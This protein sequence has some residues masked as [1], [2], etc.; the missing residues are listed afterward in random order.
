MGKIT[1]D[2]STSS[3]TSDDSNKGGL[4]DVHLVDT[5]GTFDST[6]SEDNT[7]RSAAYLRVI[8]GSSLSDPSEPVKDL[9]YEGSAEEN[10]CEEKTYQQTGFEKWLNILLCRGDLAKEALEA[11]PVSFTGLFLFASSKDRLM[12]YTGI[13]LSII[14]GVAQPMSMWL[15]GRL[16]NVLIVN[17]DG[18]HSDSLWD[19]GYLIVKVNAGIGLSLIVVTFLQY[20]FLRVACTNITT[21]LRTRFLQSM[22]RQDAGWCDTQKF[23]A[24]NA[25]LNEN[26]DRIRDGIGDKI[27][28]LIRG[29]SMFLSTQILSFI[30]DWQIALIMLPVGPLSCLTMS[31]MARLVSR[32][33]QKHLDSV[34][35][36]GAVLQETIMN[37]KTVQSCNGED[38]MVGKYQHELDKGRFH[39]IM[40][41]FWN[42]LFDGFF[43]LILYGFYVVGFYYGSM[44]FTDGTASAGDVF[45]VT[46]LVL[47]GAYFLGVMSPHIMCILKAR[48]AAAV[49][50]DRIDRTPTIDC[51]SDEGKVIR[52][53]KG[54][55]E[56]KDV[57]FSYPSRKARKVLKGV[58]WRADAGETVALV[59][60]SGCGKSTSIGLITRLYECSVGA[61]SIDGIDVKQL[62]IHALRRMIGIVQQEPT[63]FNGSIY[64]NI[65]LGDDTV[66]YKRVEEVCRMANAHGFIEKLQDGY[67]TVIGSGSVQLSGGQKQ[68]IAIARAIVHNPPI[69]LLDEATSALDAESEILVQT[70][71]KDASKGRTTV[72]IAHRLSTLRDVNKIVVMDAGRVVETGSHESLCQMPDGVYSKL[73]KAQQFME[74][75]AK[76]HETVDGHHDFKRNGT[77][78]SSMESTLSRSSVRDITT[79]PSFRAS[80]KEADESST[81]AASTSSKAWSAFLGKGLLQLYENCSGHYGKMVAGTIFSFLRGLELMLYVLLMSLGFQAFQ[82]FLDTTKGGYATFRVEIIWFTAFGASLGVYCMGSI[83]LGVAVYG[84]AAEN[85]VDAL[86]VRALKNIL[87]QDGAY[88]DRPETGNAKLIQRITSDAPTLKAAL[89]TRLYHVVNNLTALGSLVI[90]SLIY[91]WQIALIGIAVFTVLVGILSI[92]GSR[93]QKTL[94]DVGTLDDSPKQAVEIIENVRTIQL[95]TREGYFLG[96]YTRKLAEIRSLL[97]RASVYDSVSFAL[98]QSF[99][100]ISDMAC[101]GLGIYLIYHGITSP[102]SVFV[103]AMNC[104]TA[105]WAILFVSVSFNEI[106]R[107]KPAAESVFKII[108][109]RSPLEQASSGAEPSV[110]GDVEAKKIFFAYPSRP[111]V[112]VANGLSVKANRGE[113]VALV[114]PSGGGKSTVITLLQRFYEPNSGDIAV[115][116]KPIHGF[117]LKYL[118]SQMALVGQEPV[119]FSGSI[120]ENVRMGVPQ[121][122]LEDVIQACRTANAANFIEKLPQAYETEVGE[123]GAMMSGGQKQRIAIARALVR[124]P[125]V[126]LLDEAT[127]ALDTESERVVQTAL[128]AASSGRTTVTIAHRLSTV[129]H[130]DRIYFISNGRVME[131]GTHPE[132]VAGNGLYA[133]MIKKQELKH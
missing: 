48:V 79:K 36:A 82:D 66:S 85:V 45:I 74:P 89:D 108:N 77:N 15:S 90:V 42:G 30:I 9:E 118:R 51:Y 92:T 123:K 53:P 102:N 73:V 25:Q 26:I 104:G 27:G 23:G 47:F 86:K 57:H 39:G 4:K 95:L 91:C 121:A 78:Y 60:H 75:K 67:D 43:F 107:A 1:D 28:L 96:K 97:I 88:F 29:L 115:D 2:A 128:D 22:L 125:K 99:M 13:A 35:K 54:I 130:S 106:L 12:V 109:A 34:E 14:T 111:D 65:A 41:Y 113:T 17:G 6:T 81:D 56:F 64:E 46:N 10:V 84:W 40:T 68:R 105:S 100:Y 59:G 11:P 101:Y 3:A 83:F 21:T 8:N 69:L 80:I 133:E 55:I 87:L 71:L 20:F 52:E 49:I 103:A 19:Q 131:C 124:N 16:A 58:S 63:L 116:R 117:S 93:M 24:I 70:A 5:L 120:L 119:L 33:S 62:N 7:K 38:T 18:Y 114:G 32:A 31:F 50:Y 126:L 61:V 129:Q 98:M 132:L 127:S 37:V 72:V 76:H 44:R 94:D 110:L 122:T 112:Y